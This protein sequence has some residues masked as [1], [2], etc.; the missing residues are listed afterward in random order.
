MQLFR[1]LMPVPDIEAAAKFYGALFRAPGERVSPGRHYFMAGD[2]VFA[3]YA[4]NA[5]GDMDA[6]RPLQTETYFAVDDLEAT[7]DRVFKTGAKPSTETHHAGNLA[8]IEERPWGERSF[9]VSDPFGNPLCF[10]DS[11]TVFKGKQS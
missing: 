4:P 6:P 11:K 1:I 2:V 8:Q 9:Y 5:D 3:C 7:Y 10:V